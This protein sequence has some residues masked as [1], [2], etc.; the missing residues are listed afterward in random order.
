[1]NPSLRARGKSVQFDRQKRTS[2]KAKQLLCSLLVTALV[3]GFSAGCST[4]AGLR[5]KAKVSEADAQKIALAKVPGGT[6]KGSELEKEKGKLVW[7][8][9]IATPGTRDI[10]EVLA[11]AVTGQIVSV[12]KETPADQEKEKREKAK[13]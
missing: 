10:T 1:M 7:S 4:Q 6:I 2:M 13:K 9:D 12:E 11:D 3:A 8:F 5:A